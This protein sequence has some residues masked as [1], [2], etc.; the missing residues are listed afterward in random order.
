MA[1]AHFRRGLALKGLNEWSGAV[2]DFESAHKLQ[3]TDATNTELARAKSQLL[4]QTAKEILPAS[5][6]EG[7]ALGEPLKVGAAKPLPKSESKIQSATTEIKNQS[8]SVAST[9]ST[10]AKVQPPIP[11][12]FVFTAPKNVPEFERVIADI[13][14]DSKAVFNYLKVPCLHCA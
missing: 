1:K 9:S 13:K 2:A 8:K 7:G 14:H 3:P 5:E 12:D 6:L 11:A 10:A 4:T